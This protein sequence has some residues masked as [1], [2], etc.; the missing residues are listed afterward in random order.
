MRSEGFSIDFRVPI[1]QYATIDS[2]IVCLYFLIGKEMYDFAFHSH[3]D[4]FHP[5]DKIEFNA[6]ITDG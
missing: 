5:V 6:T 1:R 3:G 4:Q 2:G